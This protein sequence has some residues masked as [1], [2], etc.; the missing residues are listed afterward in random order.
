VTPVITGAMTIPG[1][2]E[3]LVSRRVIREGDVVVYVSMHPK[4]SQ[5]GRNFIHVEKL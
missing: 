3:A 5:D 2:R 4:L 1:V